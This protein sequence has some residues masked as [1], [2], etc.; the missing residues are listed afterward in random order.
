MHSY[1]Q[2]YNDGQKVLDA[3]GDQGEVWISGYPFAL[4][5]D[6]LK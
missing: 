5:F 3:E 2:Y 1:G 4:N 6:K